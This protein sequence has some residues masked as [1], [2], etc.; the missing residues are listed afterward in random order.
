MQKFMKL[1]TLSSKITY[2]FS[3]E[4][5]DSSILAPIPC[6]LCDIK[7]IYKHIYIWT[8]VRP[9]THMY[10]YL[11]VYFGKF[12]PWEFLETEKTELFFF[13][14]D[15]HVIYQLQLLTGLLSHVQVVQAY[16]VLAFFL[17]RM[18]NFQVLELSQDHVSPILYCGL[19]LMQPAA[20]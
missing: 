11:Y 3:R 15:L 1:N 12:T 9:H 6:R 18:Q 14:V 20:Y 10:I 5:F 13:C 16:F 8:L 17:E 4:L 19:L 2:Y 7:Y